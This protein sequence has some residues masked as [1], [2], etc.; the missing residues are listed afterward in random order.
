MMS[1]NAVGELVGGIVMLV[2]ELLMVGVP[3]ALI[4]AALCIELF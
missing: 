4:I 2:F 1:W 3:A